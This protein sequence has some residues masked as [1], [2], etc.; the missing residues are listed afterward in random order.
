[1]TDVTRRDFMKRTAGASAG[2]AMGI[3]ALARSTAAW[4]G[5]NDRVRIALIGL[6]GRGRDH[7][8]GF[9][10][11]EN[12]EIGAVCD[13]DEK[14]IEPFL[15]RYFDRRDLK[16]P[17]VAKDMRDLMSDKSIDVVS[18]A[19]P[20]HWHSLAAIWACQAGKD[21]YVEKPCSHNIFEGRQLVAA[22][23]KYDRIVQHGTQ[24][25]SSVAIQEAIEH[26]HG[27]TIGEVYMARGL[28]YRWRDSIGKEA[29]TKVPKGVDYDLW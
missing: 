9:Q 8:Q 1:M 29:D 26:L 10:K 13:V 5:A 22:A 2:T 23:R 19:T 25:R 24:I 11:L 4:A 14:L 21:V 27:G 20:N 12:V 7:I 15:K 17:K 28:C 18:I 3:G 16:R 6:R